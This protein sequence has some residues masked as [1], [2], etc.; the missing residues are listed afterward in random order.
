MEKHLTYTLRSPLITSFL[1]TYWILAQLFCTFYTERVTKLE[2]MSKS[3]ARSLILVALDITS[4]FYIPM[5]Y[6]A[7]IL[8]A[9]VWWV[10]VKLIIKSIT[11]MGYQ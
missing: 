1:S 7:R 3:E 4:N 6:Q 11:G 10:L 9:P 5:K 2:L 8:L